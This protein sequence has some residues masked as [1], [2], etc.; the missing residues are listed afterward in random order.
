MGTPE[1]MGS[2]TAVIN[3]ILKDHDAC[4]KGDGTGCPHALAW[5]FCSHEGGEMHRIGVAKYNAPSSPATAI[6]CTQRH[7]APAGDIRRGYTHAIYAYRPMCDYSEGAFVRLHIT[8]SPWRKSCVSAS[9]HGESLNHFFFGSRTAGASVG[10][11][12]RESRQRSPSRTPAARYHPPVIAPPARRGTAPH[13][14]RRGVTRPSFYERIV[15]TRQSC[16]NNRKKGFC[17]AR[18]RP[19]RRLGESLRNLE[20]RPGGVLK[21]GV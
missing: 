1:R 20:S 9:R 12:A 6:G 3:Y 11:A 7:P 4:L 21:T 19:P 15:R 8:G 18:L 16:V 17:C 10:T 14:R 5:V 13:L 2:R